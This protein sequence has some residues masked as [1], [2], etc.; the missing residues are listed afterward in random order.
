MAAFRFKVRMID[1]LPDVYVRVVTIEADIQD[2]A[3][4]TFDK[5]YPPYQDAGIWTVVVESIT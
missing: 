5:Y 1:D 3:Q 2:D 4:T